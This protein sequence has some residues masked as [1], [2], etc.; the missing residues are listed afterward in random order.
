[1]P[2]PHAM[3]HIYSVKCQEMGL[4][5]LPR[6]M[7][8][9]INVACKLIVLPTSSQISFHAVTLVKLCVSLFRWRHTHP[10][11]IGE[12]QGGTT[13]GA[14][15]AAYPD[16]KGRVEGSLRRSAQSAGDY[17]RATG[18]DADEGSKE[19]AVDTKAW[20]R[21][22]AGQNDVAAQS[23]LFWDNSWQ[24]SPVSCCL[25][26]LLAAYHIC[27]CLCGVHSHNK[28]CLSVVQNQVVCCL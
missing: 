13:G 23:G 27:E 20:G 14:R 15:G 10:R 17:L 24:S 19:T 2:S 3:T 9:L 21:S 18:R 4:F 7:P 26:L 28:S 16:G 12:A 8:G 25:I 1:M 6:Q 5:H 22:V 11:P